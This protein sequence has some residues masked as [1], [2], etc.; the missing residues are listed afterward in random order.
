MTISLTEDGQPSS[1]S[2]SVHRGAIMYSLPLNLTY[3]QTAHYYAESNDYDVTPS[4]P[5]AWALDSVSS[6]RFVSEGWVDGSAPFN[7][8]NRVP[9]AAAVAD[10]PAIWP[11]HI[12]AMARD[13]SQL[14]KV[15]PDAAAAAVGHPQ[16][17]AK[18]QQDGWQP[19]VPPASPTCLNA[20]RCGP[21]TQVVL[22][23]HGGTAL[24]IG[25]LPLSG[26]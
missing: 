21:P 5:W 13:V 17:T 15:E 23:P 16:I 11:S 22:V 10:E 1:L 4:S 6:M 25:T 3:T 7:K 12:V 20:S 14:W 24:R 19:R 26:K 9:L 18:G 2:Y 8:T